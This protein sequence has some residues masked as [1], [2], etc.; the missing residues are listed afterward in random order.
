M[1]AVLQQGVEFILWVQQY[2]STGLDTFF[3]H[4][5][6]FGGAHYL[7]MAPLVIWSIDYRIGCRLVLLLVSTLFV[8]S[9]VKDLLAQPR[10]FQVD[11]RIVSAGEH[12]YGLPSGHAQLVVVFWGVLAAWL[13]NKWFWLVA[14]LIMFLMGF[15]RVYLGVHFPTDIIGGWALGLV[16]L[17]LYMRYVD[18]FEAWARALGWRRQVSLVVAISFL[19]A[20]P[21]SD[22]FEAVLIVCLAGFFLG[23]GLGMVLAAAGDLDFDGRG[24]VWRRLLR[25]VVGM[26]GTLALIY[27]MREKIPGAEGF[28]GS[29]ILYVELAVVGFWV[30]YV[31]PCLFSRIG[32]G[33]ASS[34]G[35]AMVA[36]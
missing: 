14:V 16:T 23:S 8:N 30:S 24:A 3:R 10:P 17:I 36:G 18:A 26:S 31:A 2:Q 20:L 34:R 7:Y 15:S 27:L 25:Y 32:L 11:D 35:P 1:D 22:S 4:F 33:S 12:G 29:V 21:G 19:M 13:Q 28:I 5:T 6:D 9:L